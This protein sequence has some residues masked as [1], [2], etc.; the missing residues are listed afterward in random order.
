MHNLREPYIKADCYLESQFHRVVC[1]RD[2]LCG[3]AWF[4]FLL[5]LAGWS[6]L[7]AVAFKAGIIGV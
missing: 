3:W 1:E 6:A 5:A 2:A 4:W 7:I